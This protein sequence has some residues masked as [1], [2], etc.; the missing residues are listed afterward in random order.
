M[1]RFVRLVS[2]HYT[3][4]K[5]SSPPPKTSTR[6]L[7]IV[8]VSNVPS[9]TENRSEGQEEQDLARAKSLYRQLGDEGNERR[10]RKDIARNLAKKRAVDIEMAT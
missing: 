7:K 8:K 4:S 9:S 1:P 2:E 3:K 6:R 10:E 5:Y